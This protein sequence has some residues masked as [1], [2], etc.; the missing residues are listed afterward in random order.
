MGR[1]SGGQIG[2]EMI[3]PKSLIDILNGS[4]KET[5]ADRMARRLKDQLFTDCRSGVPMQEARRKLFLVLKKMARKTNKKTMN[6][7]IEITNRLIRE[8]AGL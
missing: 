5:Y 7:I 8:E 3:K 6:Q 4:G 2:E 1:S